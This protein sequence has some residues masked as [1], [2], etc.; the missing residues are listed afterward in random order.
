MSRRRRAEKRRISADPKYNSV[1]A[2]KFINGMMLDG[3]KSIAAKMFYQ[4]VDKLSESAPDG[5]GFAMF[6][7]AVKNCKPM[8]EVKSRRI[9]GSNYQVPVK[10]RWERQTTLA[11]RW[12]VSEARKRKEKTFAL[13]LA[14]ELRDAAN[15]VGSTIKKRENVH[16][17]A[18]A[19]RAFAHFRF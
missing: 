14:G 7:N 3:K 2:A 10:V 17:M 11:I 5:N 13:R 4:A 19:N 12:I 6:E 1:L 15:G 9:G 8:N 16:K 18:E